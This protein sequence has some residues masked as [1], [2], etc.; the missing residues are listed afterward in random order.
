MRF[1]SVIALLP[2]SRRRDR[3]LKHLGFVSEGEVELYGERFLRYRLYATT[4]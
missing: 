1:E 4:D 2:P 3:V